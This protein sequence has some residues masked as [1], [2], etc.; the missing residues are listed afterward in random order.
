M[1]MKVFSP[2]VPHTQPRD[3]WN[4]VGLEE[5]SGIALMDKMAL[6]QIVGGDKLIIPFC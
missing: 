4:V 3:L 6:L 5:H 2:S 1:T